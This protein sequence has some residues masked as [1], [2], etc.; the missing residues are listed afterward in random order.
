[1]GIRFL[2]L[3]GLLF[4]ALKLT[5]NID[6]SW[7]YVLLPFYIEVIIRLVIKIV[8]LIIAKCLR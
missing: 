6:W 1:M 3:L 4:I 5:N 8:V 2:Y 7:W